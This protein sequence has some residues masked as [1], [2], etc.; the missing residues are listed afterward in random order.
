M[1]VK[2]PPRRDREATRA[3]IVA[4]AR[5]LF[6]ERGY[7]RVSTSQVLERAAVSR[8]GLYHH[9][10]G[11][12][13][14]FRAV[15]EELEDETV[16]RVVARLGD[17]TDPFDALVAGAEAYFDLCAEWREFQAISLGDARS[18]L[19]WEDWRDGST[20]RGLGMA[21]QLLTAAMDA[22]RIRRGDP[23]ALGYLLVAAM[24]EGGT[25]IARADDRPAARRRAGAAMR[26]LLDGLRA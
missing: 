8:G 25:M 5:E 23:E 12:L 13:A 20:P 2:E 18:V 24:I 9:F 19:S 17:V 14:L 22:G 1:P 15:W 6:A 21:M 4:S 7:A 11:K 10:D 16:E 26:L 3:R